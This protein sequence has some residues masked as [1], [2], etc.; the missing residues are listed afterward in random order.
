[1]LVAAAATLAVWLW[2]GAPAERALMTAISVVVIA[3]PCALGLATPIAVIVATGM[4][5]AR[6]VLLK[7]GDVIE[8]AARATEVLLDKTGTV[9]RGRP[10]LREVVALDPSLGREGALALAA[11]V[12][13]RSEHGVGRAIAEA[14]RALP[15]G[16]EPAVEGFRAVPGKGVV[17]RALRGRDSLVLV[18]NRTLLADHGIPVSPAADARARE[19]EARGETAV[20]LAADGA[21]AAILSVADVVRDEAAAAVAALRRLGLGVAIVSGDARATT[22][23]VAVGLGLEAIAEATPVEKREVV[24]RRQRDGARVLFVGDG[25]NDAPALTQA[26]VGVAMGRGTDV[27][28]E[29]ADAVLVRD[30]LRLLPDLVRIAR[31]TTAVIRQNVFWAFFYNLVAVPLAMSGLLHPIVAAGAMAASS[32]FVVLNSLRVR[33]ALVGEA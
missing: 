1:M 5:T 25:I 26:D 4:A 31:R 22:G 7:G 8:N 14:V 33:G 16:K 3:C 20:F 2:R 9:T 6:G 17:A 19:A 10:V 15:G 18:G 28:L 21:L 32:V 24:V 29:S 12:E 11:A 30:D 13:R 27:T 23:S